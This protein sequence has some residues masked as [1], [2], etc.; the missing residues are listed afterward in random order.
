MCI[1]DRRSRRT[2]P[3]SDDCVKL[4]RK[5]LLRQQRD[6]D[7]AHGAY[8]ELDFV[9]ATS[10][11]TPVDISN[12]RKQVFA[13]LLS[14]AGISHHRLY[15]LRHTAITLMLRA[16][17]PLT[18]VSQR[19]GHSSTQMTLDVYAHVLPGEQDDA[20]DKMSE[21]FTRLSSREK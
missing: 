11:G 6:R 20:T 17:L 19:A 3:L 12:L 9:F 21:L 4:L 15:D 16:G 5:Q 8:R 7:A 18:V 1:R 2:L 13:P 10:A 14:A